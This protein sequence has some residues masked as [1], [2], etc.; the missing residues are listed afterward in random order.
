MNNTNKDIIVVGFALFAMF[1]GAGNL[2]FPPFLGVISGESWMTGFS[3]FI[4]ADVGL[5]LLAIAAAAKCGGDVNKILDRS[6][7]TLA[8]IIGVAIMICLGPLL[9]IPRTAATTFEMGVQPIVGNSISPVIFS[10]IFFAIVLLLTIRPSKVVDII[11]KVLTPA[12]LIALAVLIIKGVVTPLGEISPKT[13]VDSV[14]SNGISQGYQTMDALGA[15]ALSTI[16]I[17]SLHNKG[18]KENSEKVKLTIK[19]GI[20]AGV[21]LCFVYGGLTYLGATISQGYAGVDISTISQTSLIVGITEQLLGYPGKVILGIIVALACLTTAIGLTS[22]T[23]QYFTKLT[24]NKLKYEVVVTIVCIFSA[25]VSN[26]GVNTI[27]K[28]SAPIL[29]M[30]YP[31]TILLVITTLFS[32][33]IKNTNIIKGAAYVTLLV[34]ILGV[35]N[36]LSST[37]GLPIHIPFLSSLP[38]AKLGFNW[39]VPAVVGGLLG[40]LVKTTECSVSP[41]LD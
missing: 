8:K 26:F 34:S 13:L 20:V 21:A 4:L 7:N 6:G 1:F 12:L 11:G 24:N 38:F 3:G 22:A 9:A 18:Y 2:I 39:I 16:V 33:K 17:A 29:D 14:F 27:I 35:V 5:A 25:I 32:N 28:V 10:I 36:S 31:V 40:S 37:Y 41:E 23:G 15:V 19:A 30:V